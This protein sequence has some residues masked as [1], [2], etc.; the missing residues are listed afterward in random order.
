M[1]EPRQAPP[2]TP[3]PPPPA[4]EPPLPC[5]RGNAPVTKSL[6]EASRH[7]PIGFATTKAASDRNGEWIVVGPLI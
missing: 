3:R 2:T 1:D 7:R 6:G 5:G 4:Y